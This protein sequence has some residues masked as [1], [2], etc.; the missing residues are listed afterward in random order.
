ML[1]GVSSI[2]CDVCSFDF[3]FFFFYR[4][5][6]L[7]LPHG[8]FLPWVLAG[9]L[10][11]AGLTDQVALRIIIAEVEPV[12]SLEV[13]IHFQTWKYLIIPGK[14]QLHFSSWAPH[15][16]TSLP[17]EYTSWFPD[18]VPEYRFLEALEG[19]HSIWQVGSGIVHSTGAKRNIWSRL[20]EGIQILTGRAQSTYQPRHNPSPPVPTPCRILKVYSCSPTLTAGLA[21]ESSPCRS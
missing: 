2:A 12:F 20:G 8:R 21:S 11:C 5:S 14:S 7:Y 9:N 17:W 18:A 13:F 10:I 6:S 16:S 19:T 1:Q 15:L 4:F 3:F